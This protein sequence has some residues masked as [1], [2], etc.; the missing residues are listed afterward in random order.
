[1]ISA[2]EGEFNNQEDGMVHSVKS[3]PISP[4]IHIITQWGPYMSMVAKIWLPEADLDRA[5]AEC[6]IC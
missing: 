4:A 5:A 6:Q 1:M 2:E 3:Q